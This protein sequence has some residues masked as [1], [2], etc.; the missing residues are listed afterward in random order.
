MPLPA[1]PRLPANQGDLDLAFMRDADVVVEE[2]TAAKREGVGCI[3]DGGHPD[4]GR[5]VAFLR[6]LSMKP[7][8]PHR[9]PA[10]ASIR[11]RS[12]RKRSGR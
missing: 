1:W 12:T 8:L 6:Q 7:G 2:L 3:V 10:P 4:M 5:S 11:N 9:A